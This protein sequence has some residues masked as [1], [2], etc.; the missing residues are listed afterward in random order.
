LPTLNARSPLSAVLGEPDAKA[1]LDELVPDLMDSP[2]ARSLVEF[3]TG[4]LL[5][6]MLGDDDPRV[7]AV[8]YRVGNIE[9]PRPARIEE[10]M[11]V[12]D[13]GYEAESVARA[14]AVVTLPPLVR[15]LEL[16][17]VVLDG[18][19]HGNP[20]IDVDVSATFTSAGQSI[21]VGGFYD[22]DGRYVIRFLPR[23]AGPWE[24]VT[25]SNARSLD[26]VAGVIDVEDSDLPGPVG[27]VDEFHFAYANGTPF[28]PLG[29]TAYVWNHQSEALQQQ[30]LD[31]LRGAPF[32]KI[33]MCVFPKDMIYNSN[34]PD[35]YV[36]ERRPDG[37]WDT[38]RFD[39]EYWRHLENLLGQ[40]GELGIQA[41]L[42][43]FHP[44]DARWSLS[45]Q[46]S[47][48]D[49]RYVR[50]LARRLSAFP[51]VWWSMANEYDLLVNK[52]LEDWDRLAN[53]LREEDHVGHLISIHN[54]ME[55]WD[56]SSDWVTHCSIQ[57]GENL[58]KSVDKWRRTWRKPV[59]VDETGYEGD[60]DQG[61]GSLTGKD[62]VRRFWE[63]RLRGGYASH[64]E[65]FYRADEQIWWSK[66]GVLRGDSISRL[67]FLQR[68]ASDSPTGRLDPLPSDW[69]AT[70]G[71]VAGQYCV[72][73]FGD[74][75]PVF[76]DVAIP[77]GMTA[78]IDVIDTWLMT[79]TTLPGVHSGTVRVD[80]PARPYVA[81][82]LRAST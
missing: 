22:G 32:N 82:R 65:T 31:T 12:P 76:R 33:R 34:D 36:W 35:H 5:T 19:S 46:S 61:W 1:V 28:L 59:L 69:D 10:P 14:S 55:I 67:D 26:G 13:A 7:D 4:S 70:W 74:H 51:H 54:W 44:Y 49:D 11:I 38:T 62:L 75:Q 50:Y 6:L 15:R 8:I 17:E 43:I 25:S 56:A 20:F 66:G 23:S 58:A 29:T 24:F 57:H 78:E 37:S 39:L 16:A 47:T 73:Y 77:A 45:N 71:G 21:R 40:L 81:I 41:D 60:L 30:T 72:I 27:V 18:P 2:I 9:D 42:I 68:I 3:P 79:V 52:S 64:G 80:L 48:A 63:V 53:L